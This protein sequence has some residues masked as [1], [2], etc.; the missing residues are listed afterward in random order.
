MAKRPIM[1][2]ETNIQL[3]FVSS[4]LPFNQVSSLFCLPACQRAAWMGE[5]CWQGCLAWVKPLVLLGMRDI[6]VSQ[7][8]S[9]LPQLIVDANHWPHERHFNSAPACTQTQT[10][11]THPTYVGVCEHLCVLSLGISLCLKVEKNSFCKLA[12]VENM[13]QKYQN[14]MLNLELLSNLNACENAGKLRQL[15]GAPPPPPC[16][17]ALAQKKRKSNNSISFIFS[18]A[19]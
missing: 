15:I 4:S 13:F 19:L 5:K 14:S 8:T 2:A 9:G 1:P 7:Q 12:L 10:S 3:R 16:P 6:T 18:A 11:G 17:P